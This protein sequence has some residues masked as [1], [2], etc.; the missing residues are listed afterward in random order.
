MCSF[1]GSAGQAIITRNSAYLFIDP[2]YW[3]Q[4]ENEVDDNWTLSRAGSPGEPQDW[5]SW[6]VV[7]NLPVGNTDGWNSNFVLGACERFK[8]RD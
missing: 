2:R 1:S 6:L 5:I 3:V 8:D 4:A 7:C